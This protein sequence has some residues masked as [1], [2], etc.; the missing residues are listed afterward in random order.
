MQYAAEYIEIHTQKGKISAAFFT[1]QALRLSVS[2]DKADE[3]EKLLQ[4]L[5]NHLIHRPLPYQLDVI[6]AID[7][8]T[9]I[10]DVEKLIKN[11]NSGYTDSVYAMLNQEFENLNSDQSADKVRK[12]RIPVC[13]HPQYANDIQQLAS[14]KKMRWEGIAEI[15]TSV[16]YKVR[17]LGFLPGFA[18]MTEVPEAVQVERH[19]E[20]RRRVE[21]GS[22]GI[23]GKQTGIYPMPSPGGWF[24]I[25][26][27][28]IRIFLPER[29]HAPTLFLP[30]DEVTFY[31][32]SPEEFEH[33]PVSQY[34]PVVAWV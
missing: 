13:Y 20:P 16:S 24:I 27:T 28:P 14:L 32:I 8:L 29:E 15:H 22:V 23:A 9:V 3:Q 10:F 11:Y 2:A 12:L 1:E 19:A 21:A 4:H 25:G 30:G 6:P 26:R 17:T 31:S 5:F 33:F 7:S 18:Y 34:N